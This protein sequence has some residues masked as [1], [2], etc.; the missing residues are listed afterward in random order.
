MRLII[1]ARSSDLARVQAYEVGDALKAAYPDIALEFLFRQSLGDK[2]QHDPL[3]KMPEKG[4]FTQDF[5]ADL[6]TGVF[7][8]VVHSW[9]DLPV[10]LQEGSQI[11]CTLPRADTRDLL[12]LPQKNLQAIKERKSLMVLSSSPRRAYNLAPFLKAYF[13]VALSTIEFL[14]VR[15]NILTRLQKLLDGQGD[16]L[17]V[18]KAALDRLLKT[19]RE[20]LFEARSFVKSVLENCKWM[21]LPLSENPT[22]AAQ[23][24]LAVEIKADNTALFDL[25]KA[26]NSQEDFNQVQR[27]REILASYGGGCHQKIGITIIPSEHGPI[28]FLRGKTDQGEILEVQN[29]LNDT[30]DPPAKKNFYVSSSQDWFER[31]AIANVKN[32]RTPLWVTK[33]DALPEA[34]EVSA[35]QL[36]WTSG[37]KTWKKLAARGIWVNGS[38]EGLGEENDQQLNYFTTKIWTK[39]SHLEGYHNPSMQY[40]ATYA[41]VPKKNFPDLNG[42]EEFFWNSASSFDLALQHNPWLLAKKHYCGLGFTFECLKTKTPSVIPNLFRDLFDSEASSG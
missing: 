26:I 27:E 24:A 31:Q 19:E 1:A 32:P 15:G 23:G 9:K 6:M 17:I 38:A 39:L 12:L 29:F 34:W 18:A 5:H 3:W 42:Y 21:V 7:D 40:L 22:A 14:D 16:A 33:A 20:E 8:M 41:L 35:T 4:V 11:A 2:N 10:A 30:F 37:L 36:V 25:L 28:K 13:P